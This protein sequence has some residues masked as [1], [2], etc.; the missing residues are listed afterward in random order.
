[1]RIVTNWFLFVF[2]LRNSSFILNLT[3]LNLVT[4]NQLKLVY[5]NNMFLINFN[6]KVFLTIREFVNIN[7]VGPAI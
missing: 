1:M 7:M 6:F 5:K 3:K 4:L 2:L